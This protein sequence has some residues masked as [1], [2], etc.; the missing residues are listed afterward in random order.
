MVFIL[1]VAAPRWALPPIGRNRAGD[2]DTLNRM[3]ATRLVDLA[4][5]RCCVR[6]VVMSI[7]APPLASA[8]AGLVRSDPHRPGIGRERTR[9]GFRYRDPSGAEIKDEET[10]DRI[11]A[12]R[13]PPAWENVW[14]SPEPLGHIQATGVDSKGRLQY[15]YHQMWREQRDAQKFGHMLRFASALPSLRTATLEDLRRRG[16]TRERVVA[17]VVRLIDLGLFRIGGERYAELD[18]HYGATTLLKQH[19]R[20][21][22]EGVLFDYIA[23]AGKHRTIVVRDEL[24]VPTIRALVRTDHGHETLFCYQQGNGWHP[25]HSRDV[26]NYIATRAPGHFTAKEFRTWHA[27]VLMALALANAGPSPD[28]K[29]RKRVI[30]A[31]VKEVAGWLGDTPAVARGSYIDPRLITRYETDGQLLTVPATPA[32]LP[33]PAEVEA[34]VAELLAASDE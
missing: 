21:T 13:I 19:V 20:L 28:E 17:A 23:K 24:I 5:D 14:I 9:P 30:S 31:C 33:T 11:R 22:R 25:I 18:H 32:E 29:R 15:L 10:L 6:W 27:T 2:L 7:D 16:L 1:P 4:V 12:L 8:V 34:A 3:F 26:G